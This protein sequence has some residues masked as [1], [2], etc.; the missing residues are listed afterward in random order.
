M[1]SLSSVANVFAV[2]AFQVEK[3]LAVVSSAL[4]PALA[5][6]PPSPGRA[7]GWG[8]GPVQGSRLCMALPGG[9]EP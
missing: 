4:T 7:S 2:A 6:G 8:A 3:R 9:A 5:G 1:A